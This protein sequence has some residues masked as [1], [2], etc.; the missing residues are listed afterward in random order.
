M[1]KEIF[2]IDSFGLSDVGLVREHNEDA[3]AALPEAGLFVLADGMGGHLA[4]EVASKEAID[5]LQ[6]LVEEWDPVS[7]CTLEEAVAFF[8][9]AFVK[10]NTWIYQMGQTSEKF[11]GMGTTLVALYFLR[12]HAV[13]S[14]IGDSRV[15][16]Q[17]NGRLDR[18][19]ED[20][21]FVSELLAL[22]AMKS[23]KATSF[24]YKHILTRAV[25]THAKVE[26]TVNSIEVNSHDLFL[27][28]SDG[29]TNYVTDNEIEKMLLADSSF[30]SKGQCIVDFANEMGGGDN[31]TLI[32]V[33][34]DDLP[35]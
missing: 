17:S 34:V 26:P 23:E 11:K 28:C 10:V 5:Y 25:G 16:R 24:P 30:T 19:T 8:R 3:W 1:I 27:L 32:L 22:G 7:N 2:K 13:I 14:H 35:R 33:G 15:Y 31:I 20:H 29:L 4:G 9:E 21:S 18:L 6:K 12:G